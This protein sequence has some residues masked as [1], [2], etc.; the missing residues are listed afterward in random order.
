MMKQAQNI[1]KLSDGIRNIISKLTI[2]TLLVVIMC[3]LGILVLSLFLPPA[4]DWSKVFRPAALALINGRSPYEINYFINPPWV[5]IPFLP[6]LLVPEAVGRAI[7]T[8]YALIALAYLTY[9]LGAKPI[10]SLLF[11]LSP[12]V[13]QMIQD[14]SIDWLAALGFIFPP[15]IGLF[16]VVVKPQVGIA[17]VI[18]W[19]VQ[20]WRKGRLREIIR[21]F[22]PISLVTIISLGVFGFWPLGINNALKWGVTASLWPLSI[23]IGLVL[24]VGAIRKQKIKYAMASSPFLSPYVILH[25][26]IG[27]LLAIVSS[28]PETVAAV[29]GLWIVVAIRWA[30]Y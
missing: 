29:V 25:S 4:Y 1:Y 13:I 27:P 20:S 24:I 21:V 14:G 16:F 5:L 17:V 15:Q 9:R 26:W 12:P 23:P 30:G 6:L 3:A 8:L 2:K 22:A 10:A 19:L 11:L 28:V 18:F 7:V